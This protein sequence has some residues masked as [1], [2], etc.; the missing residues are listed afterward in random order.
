M[1]FKHNRR[2]VF[3]LFQ[4]GGGLMVAAMLVVGSGA[5]FLDSVPEESWSPELQKIIRTEGSAVHWISE[6]HGTTRFGPYG[7][8]ACPDKNAMRGRK[9]IIWGDSHVEAYQV[10]DA[11]KTAPAL[12]RYLQADGIKDWVAIGLGRSAETVADLY[13]QIPAYEKVVEPVGLHAYLLVD[14]NRIL[15]DKRQ[16]W[17]KFYSKPEP[18]F[19]PNWEQPPSGFRATCLKILSRGRLQALQKMK[20]GILGSSKGGDPPFWKKLRFQPGPVGKKK[21]EPVSEPT[22]GDFEIE[23]RSMDFVLNALKERA[24]APIVIVYCPKVPNI[25][26]SAVNTDDPQRGAMDELKAKCAEHGIGFID[27]SQR[28]I[29]HEQETGEFPRGFP[30]TRPGVGHLNAVGHDLVARELN[31]YI[32]S[33]AIQ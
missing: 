13:Y 5:F 25:S 28:F 17:A 22:D 15:P 6:G 32:G 7:I 16:V 26:G 18:H 14:I 19:T 1:G 11:Q 33:G 8:A 21:A 3:G 24:S 31:D 20:V 30:N 29:Q 9:V 10:D 4:W 12:N 23:A 2:W 27:M